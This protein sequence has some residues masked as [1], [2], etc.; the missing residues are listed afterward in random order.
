MFMNIC[1]RFMQVNILVV[2]LDLFITYTIFEI[3]W[4]N[5]VGFYDKSQLIEKKTV[6]QLNEWS[7]F[8]VKVVSNIQ[9]IFD[10]WTFY[11]R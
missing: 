8:P 10:G 5:F 6:T 7:Y 11:V 9:Y 3:R 1:E 4:E 2:F